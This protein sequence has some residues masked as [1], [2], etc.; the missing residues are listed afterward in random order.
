MEVR[1]V[2][3][4]PEASQHPGLDIVELTDFR[5]EAPADEPPLRPWV[6]AAEVLVE[7]ET[8]DPASALSQAMSAVAAIGGSVASAQ[9]QV[10]NRLFDRDGEEHELPYELIGVSETARVKGCSRQHISN[11]AITDEFPKVRAALKA[12]PVW[13][14]GDVLRYLRDVDSK[15]DGR[16]RRRY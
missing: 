13:R 3:I 8:N 6:K 11:L 14:V 9:V 10:I 4:D 5:P 7:V 12:G 15:R 16:S 2:V 1:L